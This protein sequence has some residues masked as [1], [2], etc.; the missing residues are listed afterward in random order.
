M[1]AGSII[2]DLLMK[3]GMFETD[4]K[5]AEKAL[6]NFQKRAKQVGIA[7]G[8][9]FATAGT[10]VAVMVRNAVKD[11]DQLALMSTQIGLTTENLSNLR[12]AAE[13]MAGVSEGQF[14]MALRRMTRRIAEAAEGGG[15]AAAALRAIGLEADKLSKMSPDEQFRKLADAMKSTENQG[16]RLRATMAIFDTEGMP[17]VNM[18]RQ[19]SEAIR[20]FEQEAEQLGITVDGTTAAAAKE[21]TRQLTVLDGV[22][23]GLVTRITAEVLPVLVQLTS[24]F[25]DSAKGADALDKAARVAGTGMK[26][27]AS[28][29]TVIVGVFKTVGEALGGIAAT[30]VAFLSGRWSEALAINQMGGQDLIDNVKGIVSDVKGIWSDIE[31]DPEPAS[32]AIADPVNFAIPKVKAAGKKVVDEALRIWQQ[33]E[34]AIA[35]IGRELATFGMTDD[36]KMLFDL[37]IQG[38][39]S[40]QLA[41]AEAMLSALRALKDEE[42][43]RKKA[44]ERDATA[45]R[46]LDDLNLEIEALGK[47]AEWIAKRN[48]LLHAGVDAESAM[49]RAIT[50]T[51][52]EL[53]RQGKAVEQTVEIL[54]TFRSSAS[55]AL[56]DVLTGTKSLKDAFI[57][58]LDAIAARIT[59]MLAEQMIERLF[60]QMGTTQGGSSGGWIASLASMFF[61][62]GKASGGDVVPNRWNVVG[63]QGPEIFVPRTAGTIIPAAASAA[64]LGGGGGRSSTVNQN[65]YNPRMQDMATDAQKARRQARIAQR[66]STRFA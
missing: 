38:A 15:P 49:G 36:Q 30:V 27:L 16:S 53:Y 18:L 17:L 46:V 57:D 21:F 60:G 8:A 39:D 56:A 65:F 12:Y 58:M 32:D 24:K 5:R 35:R 25:T 3:T 14:D 29:G 59:Q 61:G 9:A 33:V 63:E 44:A 50:Q 11:I 10:A 42:E 66:S 20:E 52:E 47:S 22:K 40:E 19:G 31:I 64:L 26:I 7:V 4:T 55:T 51:V 41:R 34:S 23:Q 1:A 48:A 6:E 28:V 43:E 13:Q 45:Q 2:I 62:G 54:D 37:Q